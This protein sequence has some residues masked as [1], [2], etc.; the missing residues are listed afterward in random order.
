MSILDNVEFLFEFDLFLFSVDFEY[1]GFFFWNNFFISEE[2]L[3]FD[4]L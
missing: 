1:L 2:N 3:L 4:R